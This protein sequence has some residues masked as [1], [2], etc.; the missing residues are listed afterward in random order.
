[1]NTAEIISHNYFIN[2]YKLLCTCIVLKDFDDT[3]VKLAY[4]TE[5][6]RVDK[7][8]NKTIKQKKNYAFLKLSKTNPL[9]QSQISVGY[10]R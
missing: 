6:C 9:P 8:K 4:S 3:K 10:E 7:D 5:Y 1:M 2:L